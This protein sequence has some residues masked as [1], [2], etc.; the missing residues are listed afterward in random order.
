MRKILK[1]FMIS[2]F[3]IIFFIVTILWSINYYVLSFS[4]D[5]YYYNIDW[6]DE[7]FIWLVFW[8]SVI[9]NKTPSEIL[10][11]RLKV[12]QKAYEEWKIKKIIVSGDNSTITYN[13][14]QVMKNYLISIWVKADDIYMDHAWFDTYSSLYRARDIFWAEEL[15][16]FTQD[17]HLKRA[18]YL[19]NRLWLQAYWIETNLQKYYRE[20]YYD[21]REFFARIKAFLNV[22]IFNRKPKFLWDRVYII[23]DLEVEEIK[24]QILKDKND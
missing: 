6:L 7:K 10:K 4:N 15:I 3:T 8:A 20:N 1:Y 14:P 17:F 12:A 11:D 24:R 18:M 2:I 16:L 21:F 23:D 9:W 19:A 22:D 5:H 13:E